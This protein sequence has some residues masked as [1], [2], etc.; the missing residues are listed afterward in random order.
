MPEF[1]VT[2]AKVPVQQE[3]KRSPK[4]KERRRPSSNKRQTGEE[5]G[6]CESCWSKKQTPNSKKRPTGKEPGQRESC[7]RRGQMPSSNKRPRTMQ[8]LLEK[9]ASIQLQQETKDDVSPAREEGKCPTSTRN[10]GQCESHPRSGQAPNSSKRPRTTQ[11]PPEK[12]A[13]T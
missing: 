5:P 10:R 11:V 7:Q 8:V 1:P 4:V 12:R 2:S 3:R 6:Q 13:N 9:R